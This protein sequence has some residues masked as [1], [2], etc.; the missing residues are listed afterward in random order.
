MPPGDAPAGG[1]PR[2][3]VITKIFPSAADPTAGPYNRQQFAALSRLCDVQVQGTIPWFPGARVF[4][5][6]SLAGRLASAPREESF[7]GLHVEHPRYLYLP[8][9]GSQFAAELYCASLLPH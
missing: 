3:L 7:E 2:V 1:R 9:L 6:W 4:G 5:R 8:K